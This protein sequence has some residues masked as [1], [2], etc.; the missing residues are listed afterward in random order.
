VIHLHR[1]WTH[2][3]TQ[4]KA[5]FFRFICSITQASPIDVT[6]LN[7]SKDQQKENLLDIEKHATGLT[8]MEI[9]R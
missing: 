9:D 3:Y 8:V 2:L 6:F 4:R 1:A 7:D 5:G